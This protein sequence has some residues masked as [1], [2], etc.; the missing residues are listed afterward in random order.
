MKIRYLGPGDAVVVGGFGPHRRGEVK[1]YPDD[2]GEEL[3]A[4]SVKQRFEAVHPSPDEMTVKELTAALEAEG[5]EVPKGAKKA[6]LVSLLK[7]AR[8]SEA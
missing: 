2:V 8:K 3:L 7:E 6:D 1:D 4:T 5:V